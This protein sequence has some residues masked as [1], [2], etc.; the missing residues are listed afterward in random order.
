M[1][2]T[3]T[4]FGF[5]IFSVLTVFLAVGC[6][7]GHID[8]YE[9]KPPQKIYDKVALVHINSREDIDGLDADVYDESFRK[10]FNNLDEA[11]YRKQLEKTFGRNMVPTQVV[12]AGSL[13]DI[14]KDYDYET[15]SDKINASGAEALLVIKQTSWE[16][17]QEVSGIRGNVSTSYEP[18][19]RFHV[20]LIDLGSGENVWMATSAVSGD[21]Y[22]GYETIN[23][24]L[25]RKVVRKLRQRH[26]IAG[27][28]LKKAMR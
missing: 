22:A 20:Y 25:A 28:G 4:F 9:V 13:F 6:A 3:T 23:N 15:F 21:L 8:D 11:K 24:N 1:K 2:H 27:K 18:E 12:A 17:R 10:D 14:N 7:S 19:A 5:I 26:Y 16:R